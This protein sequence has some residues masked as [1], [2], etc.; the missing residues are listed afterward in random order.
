MQV[1]DL[2]GFRRAAERLDTVQPNV[3][4]RIAALESALG[5]TLFERGA[6]DVRPTT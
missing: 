6:G 2:G 3:S 4:A 1:A 5:V